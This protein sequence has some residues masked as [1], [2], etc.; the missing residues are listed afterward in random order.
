MFPIRIGLELGDGL[1]PL[2]FNFALEYAIK[3]V[4]VNQ[5]CLKLNGT[6]CPTKIKPLKIFEV[7]NWKS[8]DIQLPS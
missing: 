6:L 8:R 7:L 3:R 2:L 4:P 1:S 5:D